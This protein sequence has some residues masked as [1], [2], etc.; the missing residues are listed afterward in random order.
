MEHAAHADGC[1]VVSV[2]MYCPLGPNI[3]MLVQNSFSVCAD[4]ALINLVWFSFVCP[5]MD[6]S[7][8]LFA[9]YPSF[10]AQARCCMVCLAQ[11]QHTLYT[12]HSAYTLIHMLGELLCK[13]GLVS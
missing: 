2:Y 3:S 13:I 9:F 12:L 8:Q 10:D 11:H 7:I 5:T 6:T 4:V 1:A